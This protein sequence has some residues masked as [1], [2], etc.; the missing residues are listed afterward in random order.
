MD[1]AAVPAL[2]RKLDHSNYD[3]AIDAARALKELQ[4]SAAVEAIVARLRAD[5][6]KFPPGP[7]DPT[8]DRHLAEVGGHDTRLGK[9]RIYVDVLATMKTAEARAAAAATL[10]RWEAIYKKHAQRDAILLALGVAKQREELTRTAGEVAAAE[11]PS[12]EANRE[13]VLAAAPSIPTARKEAPTTLAA[14]PAAVDSSS[15]SLATLWTCATVAV[16]LLV[17]LVVFWKR[18]T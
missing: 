15:P 18:R 7:W 4:S 8:I 16:A 10:D 13:A 14:T 9:A 5:E 11:P 6:A 1:E 12:S 17:S 3:I 2:L